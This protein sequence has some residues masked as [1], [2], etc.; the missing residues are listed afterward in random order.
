MQMIRLWS[1][2]VVTKIPSDQSS[3]PTWAKDLAYGTVEL[4]KQDAKGIFNIAGAEV[5]ARDEFAKKIAEIFNLD[6]SY[7]QSIQTSEL[8]Q[9]AA[10]PLAGGLKL[11]KIK[12]AIGWVPHT[13]T[14]A[15]QILY[16]DYLDQQEL[17][18]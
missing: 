12:K 7:V 14:E 9:K 1:E 5:L 16:K 18:Q 8:N 15:L 17:K 10:R 6:A 13:A 2:G 4:I 11:E 3:N